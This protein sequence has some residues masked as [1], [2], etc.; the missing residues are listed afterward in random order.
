MEKRLLQGMAL[1]L[2]VSTGTTW[3]T[4]APKKLAGDVTARKAYWEY[5]KQA[6]N[7]KNSPK[8]LD[9]VAA[10]QNKILANCDVAPD[11]IDEVKPAYKEVVKAQQDYIK[12]YL[13]KQEAAAQILKKVEAAAP[14]DSKNLALFPSTPERQLWALANLETTM[15]AIKGI[16]F[17][18]PFVSAPTSDNH[19]EYIDY[20]INHNLSFADC[21]PEAITGKKLSIAQK[22]AE[23]ETEG[24]KAYKLSYTLKL[25]LQKMNTHN[26]L[27]IGYASA[28]A[29]IFADA[30]KA[31]KIKINT[32]ELQKYI[33]SDLTEDVYDSFL[34]EFFTKLKK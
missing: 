7:V 26:A 20:I 11:K 25:A 16:S 29:T 17:K 4:D 18:W 21:I 10:E 13:A 1:V 33:R 8:Q 30:T 23:E 3:G 14:E 34:T 5:F 31:E 12:T 28:L 22:R 2:L 32:D 9:K 6:Q 24:S 19:Q 15:T 27:N